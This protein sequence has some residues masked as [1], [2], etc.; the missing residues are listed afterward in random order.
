M[1]KVPMNNITASSTSPIRKVISDLFALQ[2]A[3]LSAI[4]NYALDHKLM[5]KDQVDQALKNHYSSSY[6]YNKFIV[7]VRRARKA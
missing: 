5:T 4:I 1:S 2:R 6:I 7:P 3:P